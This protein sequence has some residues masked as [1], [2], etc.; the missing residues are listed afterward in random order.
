MDAEK[1]ELSLQIEKLKSELK[2]QEIVSKRLELDLSMKQN[3]ALVCVNDFLED[4]FI[5]NDVY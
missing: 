5:N 3:E 2:S 1:N 4:K